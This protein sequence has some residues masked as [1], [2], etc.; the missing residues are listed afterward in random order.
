VASPATVSRCGMVY[1]EPQAMG[2]DVLFESWY[3]SIPQNIAKSTKIMKCLKDM[4]LIF[5]EVIIRE[6]RFFLKEM[7]TTMD[8][9]ICQSLMRIIDSY[10]V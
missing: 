4:K 9:N 10:F 5:V 8:N 3:D 7:V 2:T 6:L 1:T